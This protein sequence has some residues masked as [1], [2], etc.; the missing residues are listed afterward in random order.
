MFKKMKPSFPF[1]IVWGMLFIACQKEKQDMSEKPSSVTKHTSRLGLLLNQA[2]ERCRISLKTA[3]TYTANFRNYMEQVENKKPGAYTTAYTIPTEG[4]LDII[5]VAENN[6]KKLKAIRAYKGL[7]N[8]EEALVYVG[9][10]EEGNDLIP[11]DVEANISRFTF[12]IEDNAGLCPP[13]CNYA[14]NILNGS[15]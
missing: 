6:G 12:P 10:D 5:E 2:S 7:K 3:A 1:V 14:P 9:V 13:N 11:N 8:G 15:K 4:L